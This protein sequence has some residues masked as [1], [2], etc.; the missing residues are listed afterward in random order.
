MD[1]IQQRHRLAHKL[2]GDRDH[3]TQV[4][5]DE[6]SFGFFLVAFFALGKGDFHLS[7]QQRNLPDLSQ[8]HLNRILRD[9]R[10]SHTTRVLT[11]AD[12]LIHVIAF[13]GATKDTLLHLNKVHADAFELVKKCFKDI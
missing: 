10:Q 4:G 11:H 8:V 13:L 2:F 1:Q 7:C 3:Q 9:L 5:F 6:T 12:L